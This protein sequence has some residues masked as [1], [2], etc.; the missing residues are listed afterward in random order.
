MDAP[1]PLDFTWY[2]REVFPVLEEAPTDDSRSV[3]QLLQV[4]ELSVRGGVR[5]P[6]AT[7]A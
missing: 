7:T 6:G 3:A 4:L 5:D 2:H 1:G